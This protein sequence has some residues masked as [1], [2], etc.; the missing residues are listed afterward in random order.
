M[1]QYYAFEPVWYRGYAI[2][3]ERI[4]EMGEDIKPL[5]RAH[6]GE[7]E[8]LYIEGEC[9]PDYVRYIESEKANQFVV[10]TV[11]KS[12]QMVGYL[13]YYV[14]RHMHTQDFYIAR[15]DAF[16]LLKEH[17]GGGLA[18]KLLSYAENGLKELGCKYAGMSSKAPA[19]G[20]DI[21]KF[22]ERKGY[23]P[24]ATYYSKIL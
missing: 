11:R 20:P 1:T 12:G 17:R 9:D 8:V 2:G 16:F 3:L 13:Q 24:V 15:E 22:L 5:H 19:G 7:T 21:G 6:F 10:F 23:K 4:A 14:F 18:A